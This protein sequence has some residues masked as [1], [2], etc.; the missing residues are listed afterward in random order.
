M[1]PLNVI[2]VGCTPDVLPPLRQEL[3]KQAVRI[4]TECPDAASLVAHERKAMGRSERFAEWSAR[5]T[6]LEKRRLYLIQ[7]QSL[8]NLR[9][10]QWLTST[11]PGHPVLALMQAGNEELTVIHAMREGA[12][13]VVLLPLQ[14]EDF[15]AA[16]NR[17][18]QQ[19]GPSTATRVFAVSGINGGCGA[20]TVAINLAYEMAHLHHHRCILAELSPQMGAL[21]TYLDVRPQ[22]TIRDLFPVV[23]QQGTYAIKKA[24]TRVAE[25]LEILTGPHQAI[26][27][28]TVTSREVVHLIDCTR[29]LAEVVVLDVPCTFDN[30]FFD[31]LA[32]ADQIVFVAEQKVLSL[33]TLKLLR[34][35][36]ARSVTP[37]VQHLVIN[38]YDPKIEGFSA[39]E[40][41]QLLGVSELTTIHNDWTAVSSALNHGRPLRLEAPQCRALADLDALASR[42]LGL[43]QPQKRTGLFSQLRRAL[44]LS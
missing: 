13:Q 5:I 6:P 18:A 17:I 33:R 3:A 36:M 34:D 42:L 27:P 25:G 9:D 43:S 31:T 26:A 37:R 39:P 24:L 28:L 7:L 10:L 16:L 41:K 19:H 35:S 20:T 12:V 40:L 44:G 2:L 1:Y 22:F 15:Q 8:K 29:R 38:R 30:L 11:F 21:A 23:E 32:T 4:E 14:T